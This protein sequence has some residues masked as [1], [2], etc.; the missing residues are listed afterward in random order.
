MGQTTEAIM[1][2]KLRSRSRKWGL[3]GETGE[4]PFISWASAFQTK[5]NENV[6]RGVFVF[7]RPW[8]HANNDEHIVY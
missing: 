5:V 7:E 6:G 1:A 4:R 8:S 3:I 2:C